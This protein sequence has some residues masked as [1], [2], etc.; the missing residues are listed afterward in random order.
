M[1]DDALV[2]R[3]QARDGAH[4]RRVDREQPARHVD[5]L[6]QAACERH[7]HAVVVARVEVEVGDR[8][9]HERRR[10]LRRTAEQLGETETVALGAQRRA[11]ERAAVADRAVDGVHQGRPVALQGPCTRL[12][13]AGEEGVERG[14]GALVAL[15][16][17]AQ[18]DVE[19]AVEE[20]D[21]QVLPPADGTARG[22]MDHARQSVG[23]QK[24]LRQGAQPVG[25]SGDVLGGSGMG[26]RGVH[27]SLGG[28]GGGRL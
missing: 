19:Q 11:V 1:Q 26:G 2:S 25:Q 13:R 17:L 6:D 8:A 27:A 9:A 10:A 24:V 14:V 5:H 21:Q 3:E 22:A 18:V 23:R 20:V 16:G 15:R 7:V 28:V 12:Q 4:R